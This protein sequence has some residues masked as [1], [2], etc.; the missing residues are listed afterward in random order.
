MKKRIW[1]TLSPFFPDVTKKE[2]IVGMNIANASFSRAM[3][4]Y[5]TFDELHFFV[6]SGIQADRVHNIYQE[7]IQNFKGE[8]KFFRREELPEQMA[9]VD[10]TAFHLSDHLQN[11]SSLAYLRNRYGHFPITAFI[12][13]LSYQ[14]SMKH[15]LTLSMDGLGQSD[16]FLCSSTPGAEVIAHLMSHAAASLGKEPSSSQ[17]IVVPLGVEDIAG[18]YSVKTARKKLSIPSNA[19]VGLYFGR[20]S[21]YDKMDL[22]PLLQAFQW[23]LKKT[24]D[25]FLVLAGNVQSEEY[26]EIL[27][28]WSQMLQIH[29]RVLFLRS[30]G[31]T[32]KRVLYNTSDFF[33]SISDNPQETFGLSLVEAMSASLPLLVSDYNGYKEVAS[34]AVS[35]KVPTIWGKFPY[36][37]ELSPFLDASSLHRHLAQSL[38]LDNRVLREGLL[39]L[40]SSAP[41]RAKLGRAGRERFLSLYH[42]PVVIQKLESIWDRLKSNYVPVPST[43]DPLAMP[44]FETFQHYP[45]EFLSQNM[46]LQHSDFFREWQKK[47][48]EYPILTNL[49]WAIKRENIDWLSARLGNAHLVG[50]LEQIWPKETWAL[51]YTL[52]WMLKHDLLEKV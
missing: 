21:D 29:E 36:M 25:A 12:H 15:Y 35:I 6:Y 19:V 32:L 50:D 8:V 28:L 9:S 49:N 47:G 48:V 33:I 23:V 10:Y 18:F 31:E 44:Y 1:G 40:F 38:A 37:Q 11:F 26:F 30:P 20:F 43:T 16:A 13:S 5:S 51:H 24:P 4:R 39:H 42:S 27:R 14:D 52:L 22:F 46:R 34:D 7:D 3:L 2:A 45:T 41:L 17:R